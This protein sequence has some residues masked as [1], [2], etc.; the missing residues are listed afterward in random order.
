MERLRELFLSEVAFVCCCCCVEKRRRRES[1]ASEL[2][3]KPRAKIW[4]GRVGRQGGRVQG[5]KCTVHSYPLYYTI[6]KL[7]L[8]SWVQTRSAHVI[9][10]FFRPLFVTLFPSNV[11]GQRDCGEARCLVPSSRTHWPT[12]P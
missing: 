5:S 3:S 1:S 6:R 9:G 2:T 12:W 10:V 8:T 4:T 7:D 11:K